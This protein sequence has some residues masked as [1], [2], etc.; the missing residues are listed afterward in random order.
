MHPLP[1]PATIAAQ[2][3]VAGV[4]LPALAATLIQV[5]EGCKLTAY[6]DSGGV[7]SIGYGTTRI[8]GQ[9]VTAGMTITA[10]QAAEYLAKDQAGL[11]SMVAGRPLLEAA[12]LVSF[13]YNCGAMTLQGVLRN[14]T[15][16]GVFV[17]DRAGNTLPGLVSRRNLEQTLIDLSR[18]MAS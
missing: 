13:G 1:P 7:W 4:T 8:N 11:F 6:Q 2:S 18:Q 15:H 3:Q 9:P 10:E 17:H 5:F 16:L 14:G 12:A